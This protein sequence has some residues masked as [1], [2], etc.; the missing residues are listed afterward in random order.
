MSGMPRLS[1]HLIRIG[2]ERGVEGLEGYAEL[3]EPYDAVE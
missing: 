2:E 3:I 1:E